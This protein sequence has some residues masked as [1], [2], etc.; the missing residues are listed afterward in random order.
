MTQTL[1]VGA[2]K[3]VLV[4]IGVVIAIGVA[5]LVTAVSGYIQNRDRVIFSVGHGIWASALFLLFVGLWWVVWGFR[6]IDENLWSYFTLIFLLVGPCLMYLAATLLMP[7]LPDEGDFDLGDALH[8]VA[9][10][11]FLC[12]LGVMIWLTCAEIWLLREPWLIL[13]KRGFQGSALLLFAVGA[14][15]PSR[16]V[17]TWL[18]AIAFPLCVVALA[19]VRAKLA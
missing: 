14:V 1:D 9:R 6:R 3:H 16:R 17:A 13:P 7:D 4:P 18:A 19:T 8:R 2:F 5:R 15:F 10:P 11:F 12:M